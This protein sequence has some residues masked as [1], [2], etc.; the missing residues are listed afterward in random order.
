LSTTPYGIPVIRQWLNDF[1][2][3][4][5]VGLSYGTND[6]EGNIP[7]STYEANMQA[8]VQEVI[9]AGKTPIIPTLVSSPAS[10]IRT[11]GPAYKVAIAD[12]EAKYPSIIKGPDL[13]SLFYGHSTSDGWFYDSLHPSLTTGCNALQNAWINTMNSVL[14]S[15][16]SSAPRGTPRF[17]RRR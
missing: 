12:L 15:A 9:A 8:L 11:N 14:Y 5:Y 1:P 10:A 6:A 13:W 3:V 16:A 2:A 17:Q 7:A 4:K